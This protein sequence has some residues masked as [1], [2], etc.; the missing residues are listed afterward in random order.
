MITFSYEMG[1]QIPTFEVLL[2]KH[3]ADV[4]FDI[5]V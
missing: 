5:N 4:F 3:E 2:Q 1:K